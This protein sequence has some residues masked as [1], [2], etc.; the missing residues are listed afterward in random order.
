VWLRDHR[1]IFFLPRWLDAFIGGHS[2]PEAL[3]IVDEFLA[4]NPDLPVDVRRKVL[5]PRDELGRAVGIRQAQGTA[6]RGGP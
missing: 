4:A 3:R 5:Q 1:R 6:S 2:S